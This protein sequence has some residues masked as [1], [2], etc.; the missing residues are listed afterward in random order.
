MSKTLFRTRI[1]FCGMTRAG[2][3][4]LA[5]ELGVDAV[6]FVFADGS[7][8][9]L[10]PEEA[11]V[12]RNAMEPLVDAVALFK[13]NQVEEVRAV[14]KQVRPSLLQFH[15]SE[16]DAFC[17][18]FGIPYIKGIPMRGLDPEQRAGQAMQL[19]MRYPGAA[20]F[21]FDGHAQ[22]QQGGTGQIFDWS[23]IPTGLGK[24]FVLAGGLRPDNVFDAVMATL[25]WGVDV[26]SGI[27]T[28]PGIKDGDK[29]HRFVEEVRR[30]D[31][32]PD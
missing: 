28:A 15:G 10:Q 18:G 25:P 24:P 3:V 7:P 9:R 17:R 19:Q 27:E 8:R 2:D 30:A 13:D 21:L 14:V 11:R 20:A 22:G 1:K 5:S 26:A 31:C 6:G 4:R 12:L 29:M 32:H 16:D 23:T